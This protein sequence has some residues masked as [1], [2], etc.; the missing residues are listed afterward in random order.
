MVLLVYSLIPRPHPLMRRN[1]LVNQFLGLAGAFATVQP[2]NIQNILRK[3]RSKKVR[4]LEGRCKIFNVV[5]EVLRNKNW[6]AR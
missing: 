6:F 2:S 1:G 3:T 5:R 4:I